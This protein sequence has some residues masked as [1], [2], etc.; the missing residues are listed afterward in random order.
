MDDLEAKG[1]SVLV[2]TMLII[3][4]CLAVLL[5][6]TYGTGYVGAHL[7]H[8]GGFDARFVAFLAGSAV[9]VAGALWL[10]VR[11]LKSGGRKEPLTHK[12]R[13][14]RNILIACCIVGAIIGVVSA[15]IGRGTPDPWALYSNDPLPLTF[16]IALAALWGIALPL[17]QL[18]WH[19]RLID[20]QESDAYKMGA[21]GGMYIYIFGAP[22]WWLL[23]RGGLLPEPNGVAIYLIF[24]MTVCVIWFW[25]K[26]R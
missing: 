13:R 2:R 26:Y 8:G 18:Y 6:L 12:E 16:A 25:R 3:F 10:L 1:T 14:Y 22:V 23:W 17:L 20:E 21:L 5:L 4:S 15:I 11:T 24:T 19:R 7:E 9:L